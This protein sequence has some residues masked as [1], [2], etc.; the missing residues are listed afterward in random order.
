MLDLLKADPEV[1]ERLTDDELEALFDLGY[2]LRR[3]DEI[4]GRVFG[5]SRL[6]ARELRGRRLLYPLDRIAAGE[7]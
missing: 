4:F 1:T 3:I 5:P 6:A 2:H 7:A